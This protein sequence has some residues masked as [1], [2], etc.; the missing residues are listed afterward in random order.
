MT[1]PNFRS[2][3]RLLRLVALL[4]GV[5]LGAADVRA[6][7]L[8]VT[9]TDDTERGTCAP[10]DCS[11]REAIEAANALTMEASTIT[12]PAGTYVLSIAQRL[13]MTA[14][15]TITGAGPATTIVDGNHLVGVFDTES[16]DE[17]D[18][19]TVRHRLDASGQGRGGTYHTGRLTPAAPVLP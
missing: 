4:G 3:A 6:A 2:R 18:G 9:R 1:G 10:G 14:D 8:T 15:I 11:L 5:A 13:S 17:I 19:V 12:L 7:S 16:T